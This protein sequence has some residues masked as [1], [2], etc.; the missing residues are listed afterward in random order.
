MTRPLGK[1]LALLQAINTEAL[2]L[3]HF[4]CGQDS[5]STGTDL[6][7]YEQPFLC[8]FR[9]IVQSCGLTM[10]DTAR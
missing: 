4:A 9:V 10:A 7:E 2:P 5:S 1:S 6:R 8:M 3:L